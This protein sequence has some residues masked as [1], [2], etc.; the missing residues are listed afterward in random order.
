MGEGYETNEYGEVVMEIDNARYGNDTNDSLVHMFGDGNGGGIDDTGWLYDQLDI[1]LLAGS[2]VIEIGAYNNDATYGDEFV[3]VFLDDVWITTVLTDQCE[4]DDGLFC[5]GEET[6]VDDECVPGP[7]PC[8]GQLCRESDDTCVDCLIDDDCDDLLYCNGIETCDAGGYCQNG[9]D[10]DCNDGVDCTMDTCNEDSDSCD[11]IPDDAYCDNGLFCDGAEW[12]DALLDCQAGEYPC[13]PEETCNEE[14][15]V[16]EA[17]HYCATLPTVSVCIGD[18]NCDGMVDPTDTGLVK[19]WYGDT[20]PDNLCHCDINCDGQIDPTDVGL[21]K[22]YYGP[23][24]AE[25]ED[26]CWMGP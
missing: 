22:F 6:C 20:D 12:C 17:E 3:E 21:V 16:C 9:P 2:H 13:G 14:Q 23:C 1:P 4:C 7:D 11:N 10:V 24:T 18:A 25:S 19:Y 8:P 5:N 15:D 26:P